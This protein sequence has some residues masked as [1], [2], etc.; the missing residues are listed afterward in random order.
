MTENNQYYFEDI[1]NEAIFK[2]DGP[3]PHFLI[4]T[5]KFKVLVV[6]L[7]AGGKIPVHPG[8][9][10]MYHFLEGE[11]TMTVDDETFNIK[12]GSTVIVPGGER[13]GI[14]ARTRLIFLGS[15]GDE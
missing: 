14:N 15:K 4:E 11:G 1:K 9:A 5:P 2:N 10:A 13:R 3:R 6:G 12:A 8:E 7:D